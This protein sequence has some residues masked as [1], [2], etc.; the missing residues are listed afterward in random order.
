MPRKIGFST[1][2]EN[3]H[4]SEITD[5]EWEF[6]QAIAAYQKQW[7]RRYPSWREVFHVLRSLGYQKV[8]TPSCDAVPVTATAVPADASSPDAPKAQTH[9]KPAA[10]RR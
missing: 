10:S 3:F 1:Y 9:H 6:I 5:E 2:S 4:G 8:T 7:N